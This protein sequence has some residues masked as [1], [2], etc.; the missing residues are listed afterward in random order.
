MVTPQREMTIGPASAFGTRA[1]PYLTTDTGTTGSGYYYTTELYNKVIEGM[2]NASGVLEANP[3]IIQTNHMRPIEAPVDGD[4]TATLGVEGSPATDANT[5][6]SSVTLAATRF[7]GNFQCSIEMLQSSDYDL[8][9]LLGDF[10]ARSIA[11]K[12]AAELALRRHHGQQ[13]RLLRRRREHRQDVCIGYRRD[14]R[15]VD[16]VR[17]GGAERLPEEHEHRRE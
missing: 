3:T 13:G 10:A 17:E 8:E 11:N 6:G 12:V 14:R 5:T 1:N 16:S 4:A 7:D 15:R 9:R 2:L